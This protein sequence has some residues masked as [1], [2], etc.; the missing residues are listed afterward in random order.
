MIN[1]PLFWIV[2]AVS[3]AVYW[4]LPLVPR[5][6]FLAV[7][8]LGLLLFFDPLSAVLLVAMAGL[9]YASMPLL[10][11]GTRTSG[12]IAIALILALI[13]PLVVFKSGVLLDIL[14]GDRALSAG[15]V[16]V[17]LG[18][19]YYV[20]RLTHVVIDTYRTQTAGFTPSQYLAYVF[21]FTIMPA[22]PIQRVQ[23]FIE[24]EAQAFHSDHI[25]HGLFRI[26]IGLVKQI[27]VLDYLLS[28]RV[29]LTKVP[30]TVTLHALETVSYPKLWVLIVVGYLGSLLNLSAYT[31]IAIGASRLFGFKIS[32]NFNYP[33]IAT[34][35]TDFWRRWHI[36][37]SGWCQ[38]YVYTPVLGWSRNPYLA[39]LLSF[40]VMGLWH[41]L[42]FNRMSWGLFHAAGVAAVAIQQR[43]A[44]RLKIK[45]S[46]TIPGLALSWLLTQAF[47]SASWI[48]VIAETEAS[49]SRS[50]LVLSRLFLG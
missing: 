45:W 28:A 31:D 11:A 47:V 50:W 13:V 48:F 29:A 26:G 23:P 3:V 5:R 1:D 22:G 7:V 20:F 14:K 42:S 15:D 27:V 34:S 6:L 41:V 44:R 8:G 17:P 40:Q 32:E 12:A 37:L 24:G 4:L 19:S 9:V 16:I 25:L 10:I 33:F 21:L 43:Y 49:V 38:S 36:T 46:D 35:L 39:L 30:G 18:M 2:L